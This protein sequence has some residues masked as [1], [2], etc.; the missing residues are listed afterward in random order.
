MSVPL[1]LQQQVQ[2]LLE[3]AEGGALVRSMDAVFQALKKANLLYEQRISARFMGVHPCNRDGSGVSADHVHCLLRD[4]VE[5]GWADAEFK[6]ICVEVSDKEAQRI[7]EYNARIVQESAGKL[8]A[9][10]DSALKFATISGSHTTQVLRLFLAGT[11]HELQS[12]TEGG[13]LSLEKLRRQDPSFWEA[14]FTGVLYKVVSHLVPEVWP[15]FCRLAQSAANASGH[16]AREENELQLCRKILARI[17][18]IHKASGPARSVTFTDVKADVLRSK[19][20]CSSSAPALFMFTLKFCGGQ[21]GHFLA[22]T[23]AFVRGHGFGTRVLGLDFYDCLSADIKATTDQRVLLRHMALQFAYGAGDEKAL[24][25]TDVK[26][27]LSPA[28]AAKADAAEGLSQQLREYCGQQ[29]VPPHVQLQGMGVLHMDIVSI[30]CE[31]KKLK[32][33]ET[34]EAAAEASIAL[35]ANLSGLQLTCPVTVQAAVTKKTPKSKSAPASSSAAPVLQ[36]RGPS[37]EPYIDID[38]IDVYVY[39]YKYMYTHL[40]MYLCM[41]QMKVCISACMYVKMYVYA[42]A[43]S[44]W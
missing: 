32:R 34:L 20:R 39:V 35:M 44:G 24:T 37:N 26:K 16:V 33:F 2:K 40:C 19:P 1:E 5:L 43:G 27:L 38:Y 28:M 18:A 11:K 14:C 12:V 7:R 23:E 41:Q 30:L 22:E 8:A 10:E 9:M 17:Q 36:H 42:G 15:T 29:G 21:T 3:E 4:I 31:K 25:S 6:G 13:H